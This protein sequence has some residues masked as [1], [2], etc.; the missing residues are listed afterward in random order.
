MAFTFICCSAK[1][2]LQSTMHKYDVDDSLVP[3]FEGGLLPEDDETELENLQQNDAGQTT[4]SRLKSLDGIRHIIREIV[5]APKDEKPGNAGLWGRQERLSSLHE[6]EQ[7]GLLEEY[8][9]LAMDAA[10]MKAREVAKKAIKAA[11]SKR[12]QRGSAGLWGKRRVPV[13][14]DIPEK[15]WQGLLHDLTDEELGAVARRVAVE[16]DHRLV[17]KVSGM[18]DTKSRKQAVRP[19]LYARGAEQ[20]D[21]RGLWGKRS[22]RHGAMKGT[23][24]V[25]KMT[26]W[27]AES[28]RELSKNRIDQPNKLGLWVGKKVAKRASSGKAQ[29][30][31]PNGESKAGLWGKKEVQEQHGNNAG[32]WGRKRENHLV[33]E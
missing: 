4:E 33:E 21:D 12:E 15:V 6:G 16:G 5:K 22:K 18:R 7:N 29:L 27:E 8:T 9:K 23:G 19:V 14:T 25:N 1:D 20:S 24:L 3:D 11:L 28:V 13:N 26:H 10:K 2:V 31:E 30:K 17:A 32:M